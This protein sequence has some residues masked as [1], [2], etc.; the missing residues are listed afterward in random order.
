MLLVR[1][2]TTAGRIQSAPTTAP[3]RHIPYTTFLSTIQAVHCFGDP[4]RQACRRRPFGL[5]HAGAWKPATNRKS[6]KNPA[7]S[8]ARVLESGA[9]KIEDG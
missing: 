7:I 8:A 6:F 9:R 4:T 3:H 1:R 2:L 5:H